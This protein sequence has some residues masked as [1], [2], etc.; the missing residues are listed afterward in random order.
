MFCLSAEVYGHHESLIYCST[1]NENTRLLIYGYA[2]RMDTAG[3]GPQVFASSLSLDF[4]FSNYFS[5]FL[6]LGRL[7]EGLYNLFYARTIV[8]VR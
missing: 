5:V 2:R 1:R 4:F 6:L 3:L 8:K 7:G